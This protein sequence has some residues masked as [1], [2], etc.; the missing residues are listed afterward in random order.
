M[1]YMILIGLNIMG[2]IFASLPSGQEEPVT[3]TR[4]K[5]LNLLPSAIRGSFKDVPMSKEEAQFLT[6]II[7]NL[8]AG[9]E[10]LA[11]ENL[12]KILPELID[13]IKKE[14]GGEA[15]LKDLFFHAVAEHNIPALTFLLNEGFDPNQSGYNDRTALMDAALDGY[16]DIVKLLLSKGVNVDAQDKN[17]RSALI[18]AVRG[19][20]LGKSGTDR[21][22][23]IKALRDKGAS[24]TRDAFHKT[25][26]DYAMSENNQDIFNALTNYVSQGGTTLLMLAA[27]NNDAKTTALLLRL[28]ANV[29]K[30]NMDGM[31]A[32]MFAAAGGYF[33]V[34]RL[35]L[36]NGARA[37]LRTSSDYNAAMLAL[38][39]GHK[40]ILRAFSELQGTMGPVEKK[41]IEK[42]YAQ[43]AQED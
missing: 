4:E 23:I 1:L 43:I 18:E 27:K 10:H 31:S 20:A 9:S 25:A 5:V 26:L 19:M 42:L 35:L 24:L 6:K 11:R 40:N 34:V 37:D 29:N 38:R 13:F 16:L 28:G 39:H 3:E 36:N 2:S 22:E 30:Q 12:K 7:S 15:W 32:L 17:K 33:D 14:K 21:I 41:E 8:P